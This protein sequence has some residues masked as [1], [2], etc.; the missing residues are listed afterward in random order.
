VESSVLMKESGPAQSSEGK[1]FATDHLLQDIGRR[2]VSGSF[3]TVGAQGLKFLLNFLAAAILA[4][5]LSPEDFGLVGM[6]LGVTALVGVFSQLGLSIATIQRDKIT[7]AQVSNLFWINVGVSGILAT[8]TVCLAPLMAKFYHDPR[9]TA[10]MLVLAVTFL[11]T[12]STVQHQALLTR[13]MRFRTLALIDVTATAFGFTLACCL[14]LFGFA[15]WVLVAQ[16]VATAACSLTMTWMVSRWRPDLP[17]RNSGVKPL[18]TF[19]AHLSLADFIGQFSYNSDSILLGRFFG[20][21]PLGLYTRANVL[22]A[23]PIQQVIIPVSNV[24]VPVLSRLRSDPERYRRSYMRAHGT[25]ALFTLSFS[26]MCL[27]LAKPLVLVILGP[28]W[29][30]AIPLFAAFTF[31]AVSAPLSIVCTWIYESQG[32]GK[33]QL[34]NHIAAGLT[35]VCSYLVGLRW[36][37]LGVVLS[38]AIASILVRLPIVYYLAGRRGPVKTRDLWMGFLSHLPC[39]GAVLLTTSLIHKVMEHATPLVQLLVCVPVG[40][41]AGAALFLLFPRPRES[42]FSAWNTIKSALIARFATT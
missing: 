24:L 2:A 19:G 23:R 32:R 11:L 9:V 20:A 14:A 42:A 22:L 16:Q 38:L 15:Y 29:A 13:Q 41:V 37:P 28:K 35:T 40:L 17:S 39:W 33:D 4:R 5:L 30:G 6:A 12:G 27:A 31:V 10:I 1:H 25:L 3:V 18:V 8:G 36:G 7:Q 34:R 21:V 26:A